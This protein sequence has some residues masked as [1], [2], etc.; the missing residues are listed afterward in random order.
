MPISNTSAAL[1]AGRGIAGL[2]AATA[3]TR[4]GRPVTVLEQ[5]PHIRGVGTGLACHPGGPPR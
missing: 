5:A 4:C 1:I 2:V 3:L